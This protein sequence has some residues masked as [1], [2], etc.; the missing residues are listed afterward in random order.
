MTLPQQPLIQRAKG[1]KA[2]MASASLSLSKLIKLQLKSWY[3]TRSF[4]QTQPTYLSSFWQSKLPQWSIHIHT[5][6]S[7]STMMEQFKLRARLT[8]LDLT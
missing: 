6:Y 8:V 7:T 2:E 4:P 3:P 5:S 1:F